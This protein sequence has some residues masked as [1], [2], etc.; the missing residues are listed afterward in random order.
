MKTIKSL[1]LVLCVFSLCSKA[2]LHTYRHFQ[3][4]AVTNR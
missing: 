2:V 3:P 1:F 4:A